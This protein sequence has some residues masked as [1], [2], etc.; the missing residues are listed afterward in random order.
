MKCPH[1]QQE[2]VRK[3]VGVCRGGLCWDSRRP[4]GKSDR[5]R[6]PETTKLQA[7]KF[8]LERVGFRGIERLLDVRPVAVMHW[9]KAQAQAQP[10]PAPIRAAEV[11]WVECDKLCT[12]VGLKRFW[13]V[14]V[15]Y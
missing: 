11:E 9:V 2:N 6:H 10:V 4:S 15:G 8:Y 13:L 12:F 7:L 14:L 1:C 5:R 3:T